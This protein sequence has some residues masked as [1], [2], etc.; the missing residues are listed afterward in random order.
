M[1]IDKYIWAIRV[2]KTRSMASSLCRDGKV[3]VDGKKV[4]ASKVLKE[5]EEFTIR[6]GAIFYTYKVL[7]FPK[8]RVGASLVSDYS[9][10]ITSKEQLE[11]LE[12]IKLANIDRPKGLGRPTKKDR[13]N[14][15]KSLGDD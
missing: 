2:A 7:S 1:R 14:W 6:K 8:S 10:D 5:G 13:R 9:E 12:M 4:K 3:E 15:A 11:K